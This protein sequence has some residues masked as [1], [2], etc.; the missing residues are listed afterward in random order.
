MSILDRV[1][2]RVEIELRND[3]LDMQEVVGMMRIERLLRLL[4]ER[5]HLEEIV[6]EI[7]ELDALV[8]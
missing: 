5:A 7:V 1:E 6:V 2:K 3:G 4:D 8:G